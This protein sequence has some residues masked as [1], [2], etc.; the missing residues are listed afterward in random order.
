[1]IRFDNISKRY[2]SGLEAL[3]R[4]SFEMSE[5]EMAFLTGP[6]GAVSYTHLR[7]HET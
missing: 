6:S 3:S 1:M 4:V 7:A 5:G 2:E